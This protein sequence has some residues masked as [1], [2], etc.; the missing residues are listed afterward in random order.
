[1]YVE[2]PEVIFCRQT[3]EKRPS[4]PRFAGFLS[5]FVVAEYIQYASLLRISRVLHLVIFERPVKNHFFNNRLCR[6]P[7]A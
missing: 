4:V 6:I 1:M 3:A 2:G 7:L 5:S